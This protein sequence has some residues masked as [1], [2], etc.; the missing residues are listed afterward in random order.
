MITLG[1]GN[2]ADIGT[3]VT[4]TVAQPHDP[5]FVKGAIGTIVEFRDGNVQIKICGHTRSI[6]AKHL[7]LHA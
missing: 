3:Q 5:I 2:Y 4:L 6:S 7:K 1:D